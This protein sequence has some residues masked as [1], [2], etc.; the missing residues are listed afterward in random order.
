MGLDV[1]LAVEIM[2]EINQRLADRL[3]R[4]VG[5][6]RPDEVAAQQVAIRA[7]A[8]ALA[9]D[10]PVDLDHAYDRR[11]GQVLILLDQV[12]RRATDTAAA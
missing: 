12:R 9:S 11:A 1:M 10:V 2:T 5:Q 8:L 4:S 6:S 3:E 7:L